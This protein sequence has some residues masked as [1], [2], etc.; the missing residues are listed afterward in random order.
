MWGFV[1]DGFYTVDDFNYN[2]YNGAYSLKPGVVNNGGESGS[3]G[4]IIGVVQPG[5]IQV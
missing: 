5:S 4:G 3:S 1:T 2:R